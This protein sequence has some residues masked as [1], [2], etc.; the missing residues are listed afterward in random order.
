[1][2]TPNGQLMPSPYIPIINRQA[3]ILMRAAA[4]LGFSPTAR[5]R[6]GVTLGGG[7]LN[8]ST[9]ATASEQESLDEYLARAPNPKAVH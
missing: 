7:E 3:T 2:E 1:V 5:P 4:E 8:G 9:N 6:I